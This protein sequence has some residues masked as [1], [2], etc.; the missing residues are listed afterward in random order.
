MKKTIRFIVLML[1]SALI[2][3][4]FSSCRV[5]RAV[6]P[7]G[8]QELI[9]DFDVMPVEIRL[10][11]YIVPINTLRIHMKLISDNITREDISL[12]L[13]AMSAYFRT[14]QFLVFMDDVQESN[15]SGEYF[16]IALYL[17]NADNENIFI[18]K[19]CPR[20]N[21]S[22]WGLGFGYMENP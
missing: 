19:T 10:V 7:E 9:D 11:R 12:L 14:E 5:T 4:S 17:F 8:F 18:L 2:M 20:I 16:S 1:V 15:T 21:F 13:N 3:V 22:Y 6:M